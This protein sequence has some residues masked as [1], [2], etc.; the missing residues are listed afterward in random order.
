MQQTYNTI[1]SRFN[2]K[3]TPTSNSSVQCLLP[4]SI[5]RVQHEYLPVLTKPICYCCSQSSFRYSD[6]WMGLK[7]GDDL[8][9][10]CTNDPYQCYDCQIS[11]VWQD[12]T[13]MSYLSWATFPNKEPGVEACARLNLLGWGD[14]RCDYKLKYIC[15]KYIGSLLHSHIF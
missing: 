1:S 6:H 8:T 10:V 14:L 4:S 3:K 15:E 2:F 12:G 5:W 13:P 11:W 7:R 9:C